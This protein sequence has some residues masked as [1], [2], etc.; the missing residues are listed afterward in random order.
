[1]LPGLPPDREI[2]F[3]IELL[4]G[5]GPL[6]KAPYRMAPAELRELKLQCN[7]KICLMRVLL[8]QVFHHGVHQFCL[9]KRRKF[10]TL[11]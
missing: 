4:P 1:M 11:Y 9:L 3:S 2:E 5:T 6:F 10:E 8:G 7:Y